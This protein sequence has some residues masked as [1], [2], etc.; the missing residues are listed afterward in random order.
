MAYANNDFSDLFNLDDFNTF[1]KSDDFSSPIISPVKPSAIG[2]TSPPAKTANFLVKLYMALQEEPPST[3]V[4]WSADGKQLVVAS[5]GQLEKDIL[6]R[7]WK[8][9]KF[10]SFGR[11]LN[12]YGFS[13]VYPGR[14][15]KDENGNIRDDASVWSHPTLHRESTL[16]EIMSVKRRAAPKLFR[17]R[18][19]ANGQVVQVRA[20]SQVEARLNVLRAEKQERFPGIWSPS[21]AIR[22]NDNPISGQLPEWGTGA[23]SI[24][25]GEKPTNRLFSNQVEPATPRQPGAVGQ[26]QYAGF[27]RDCDEVEI[28]TMTGNRTLLSPIDIIQ[29]IPHATPRRASAS[30]AWWMNGDMKPSG[31]RLQDLQALHGQGMPQ[32][33][34]TTPST[35]VGPLAFRERWNSTASDPTILTNRHMYQYESHNGVS[36]TAPV[37]PLH[38]TQTL[39]PDDQNHQASRGYPQTPEQ[40]KLQVTLCLS[41]DQQFSSDYT[42]SR[43]QP[44][45]PFSAV[46]TSQP[47]FE[48]VDFLAPATVGAYGQ[49]RGDEERLA[50]VYEDIW[51]AN[52][53]ASMTTNNKP[54]PLPSNSPHWSNEVKQ[55]TSLP[56]VTAYKYT[57]PT[58]APGVF[59]HNLG[60]LSY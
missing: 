34:W 53:M 36:Y 44:T 16:K 18:K 52:V 48:H 6:P 60:D 14:Q 46:A 35:P 55:P 57:M 51:P 33:S 21:S 11:Q 15:F 5:P 49:G 1:D 22:I 10:T 50:P 23:F 20:G 2:R 45:V 26:P 27:P 17:T 54:L 40:D 37:S 30:T 3:A 59:S 4:Y 38:G 8:H 29:A 25:S 32:K 56:Y 9:N 58:T 12:I 19:L 43:E 24:Q 31:I 47:S 7:Y 39:T 42:C 28:L 13:R 41:D